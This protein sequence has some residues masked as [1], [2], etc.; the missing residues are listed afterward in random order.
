MSR[1]LAKFRNVSFVIGRRRRRR[2][3]GRGGE[4]N[5]RLRPFVNEWNGWMEHPIVL[6]GARSPESARSLLLHGFAWRKVANWSSSGRISRTR[7]EP[8]VFGDR[9]NATKAPCIIPRIRSVFP[10]FLFF[11]LYFHYSDMIYVWIIV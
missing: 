9:I 11:L 10:S 5:S 1:L 4:G 6:V 8:R 7:L 2:G 3:E